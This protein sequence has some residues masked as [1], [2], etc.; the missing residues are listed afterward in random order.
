M[1]QV[2]IFSWQ[3]RRQLESD[4]ARITSEIGPTHIRQRLREVT[5]PGYQL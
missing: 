4:L 3:S 2:S 1:S 5:N